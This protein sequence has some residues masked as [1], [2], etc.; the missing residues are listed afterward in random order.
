[1]ALRKP[2]RR[3]ARCGGPHAQWPSR[4]GAVPT[5]AVGAAAPPQPPPR[6]VH[7]RRGGR[8]PFRA[9]Q[10]EEAVSEGVASSRGGWVR[11]GAPEPAGASLGRVAATSSSLSPAASSFSS[12][13]TREPTVLQYAASAFLQTPLLQMQIGEVAGDRLKASSLST[14]LLKKIDDKI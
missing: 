1:V 7:L 6:S 3:R 13:R 12:G 10:G 5:H 9:A 11:G 2:V 14:F 8:H 4:R